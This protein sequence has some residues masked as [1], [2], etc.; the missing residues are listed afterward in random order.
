MTFEDFVYSKGI[1]YTW[2]NREIIDELW[3]E[4]CQ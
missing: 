3:V 4:F 1:E 2:E